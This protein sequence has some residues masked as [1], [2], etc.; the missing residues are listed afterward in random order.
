M[1]LLYSSFYI[2]PGAGHFA[3]LLLYLAIFFG[4]IGWNS[5][6]A[7]E[8][9]NFNRASRNM[10]IYGLIVGIVGFVI[11]ARFLVSFYQ[12]MSNR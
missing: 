3:E 6:T 9:E 10:S 11:F 7:L 2:I 8:H 4:C 12:L 1:H 5:L